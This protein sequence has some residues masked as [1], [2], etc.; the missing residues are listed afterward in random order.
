L[1]KERRKKAIAT[2]L[3]AR[4]NEPR[5]A[6]AAAISVHHAAKRDEEAHREK[7]EKARKAVEHRTEDL[8][9]AQGAIKLATEQQLAAALDYVSSGQMNESPDSL[10]VAREGETRATDALKAAGVVLEQ[11]EK[12]LEEA[13]YRTG[14]AQKSLIPLAQAVAVSELTRLLDKAKAVQDELI[15]D[16]LALRTI[17]RGID[18]WKSDAPEVQDAVRFLRSASLPMTFG[19]TEQ[20]DWNR[21]EE[22][23]RWEAALVNLLQDPDAD[24]PF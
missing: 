8:L 18:F 5:A 13:E 7:T 4:R 24:F 22:T 17:I 3:T 10:S 11:F 14:R 15:R 12:E 1:T 21:H 20:D 23:A 2:A 16:R 9:K 19:C 6:L